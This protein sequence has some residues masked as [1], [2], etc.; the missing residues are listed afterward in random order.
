[1]RL[2]FSGKQPRLERLVWRALENSTKKRKQKKPK[3]NA[4]EGEYCPKEKFGQ[5]WAYTKGDKEKND[6]E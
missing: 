2:T 1:M 4:S 3:G 6:E 5:S